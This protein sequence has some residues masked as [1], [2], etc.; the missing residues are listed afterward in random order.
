MFKVVTTVAVLLCLAGHCCA[1][2]AD[3]RGGF[4]RQIAPL[5][6]RY[7][8]RCHGQDAQE[9]DLRIDRLNPD[10]VHSSDAGFWH[11]VLNQL[12]E[13]R[14]PPKGEAQLT[15]SEFRRLTTWLEA[16]L[17][18]AA[19]KRNS[20]GGRQVMRR[21]NRYEYQH[22]LEDLLGIA[23]DY[24][25]HMP[26]DFSGE[27][28]LQTSGRL[29]GMSPVLMESY[30]E[31]AQMA[32]AEAVP[33]GPEEIIREKQTKLQVT[34]IRGQRRLKRKKGENKTAGNRPRPS[35]IAPT[36]GFRQTYFVHD[37][38]RKVTFLKRPFAGRFAIRIEVKAT[39]ASD[40]RLPELTAHVGHRASGDYDPKK[41]VGR[42]LIAESGESQVIEFLG[43]IED[44]PLG[45]K[46]G[47]YNGSGSHNVTHLSV[48]L[49]NTATPSEKYKQTTTIEEIDEPLLE[50]LS[51]EFEGP[52]LA[53]YPSQTSRGLVPQEVAASQ[54]LAVA[55][56][57][58]RRFLRRAWRRDVSDQ[59]VQRALTAFKSFRGAADSFHA[60]MRDTMAMVLISPEFIYLVEREPLGKASLGRGPLESGKRRLTAFE[61]ASRLS[62]FLWASMPDEELLA[63]ASSGELL[64][65][66]VLQSQVGRMR[67]DPRFERFIRHFSS[68]WLGLSAMEH[69]AVNPKAH[70]E[71]S[72]AVRENLR[73]E[74]L[75]FAS[76]VFRNDLN[77]LRFIQSDFALLNQ[78]TASHYEIEG[79]YG[80][81]FR[82]VRV[83]NDRGGILTQGS[84]ALIGSDGTESNPIYRGVWLRKRLFADPPPLPP[85]GAPPLAKPDGS[86]LTLKEQIE[87]HRKQ[88]ACARCHSQ[89]D[90]W[91][92]AF[93]AYGATGRLKAASGRGKSGVMFDASTDLPDGSH[94]NGMVDLQGWLIK[95]RSGDLA[96]AIARRMAEYA[97]GRRLEFSDNEVVDQ[98]TDQFIRGDLR[99]STLIDGIVTSEVFLTK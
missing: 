45:K 51:V 64:K 67:Q 57:S 89:I 82:P 44:F 22:T 80:S 73:A 2:Q 58:L 92:I 11:E 21:M 41:V 7:C 91:G 16:E 72:D 34:T 94:V 54:E 87:R 10:L 96:N 61:L 39:A 24:S 30:L 95:H 13:G 79:V 59:E 8:I 63:L 32:L 1:L 52:L 23:L 65:H 83:T 62:Y 27:N 38:P 99:V 85:P 26:T 19:D 93:E 18:K 31:V 60:A 75:A 88:P 20:T 17:K 50:V 47:Y 97:L 70:P 56:A 77:C 66:K 86:K 15:S 90:P 9:A 81:R 14:M 43:N 46:D 84:V 71:F 74:T 3:D 4:E 69:V 78:V 12:N 29:L 42:R 37:Q 25:E 48:W 36:F 98:L 53:G 33:D 49:W 40:G 28:G 55:A 76:H 35:I 68:Q 6:N 5:L